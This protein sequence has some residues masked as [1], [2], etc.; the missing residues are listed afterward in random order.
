[1]RGALLVPR[2]DVVEIGE[3]RQVAVDPEI[4]AAGVAEDRVDSLTSQALQQD[5]RAC[6]DVALVDDLGLDG[7]RSMRPVG[8]RIEGRTD[9]FD[10]EFR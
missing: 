9:L 5:L 10:W 1:M 8:A 6:D 4:G 2:Q 7:G 3:L